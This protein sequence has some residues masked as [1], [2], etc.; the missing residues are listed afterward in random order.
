MISGAPDGSRWP[1][2]SRLLIYSPSE[3]SCLRSESRG[4]SIPKNESAQFSG[5]RTPL[6]VVPLLTALVSTVLFFY[7]RLWRRP[8]QIRLANR[9]SG[10]PQSMSF[11]S[12]SF[13]NG[14][15]ISPLPYKIILP[16]VM[17]TVLVWIGYQIV[18]GF[19]KPG[20]FRC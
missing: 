20:P 15:F 8:Q 3:E 16:T 6:V 7:T 5:W 2:F 14:S 17:N 12:Y 4:M 9:D 11:R 10:C 18:R 19:Q 1:T 13:P